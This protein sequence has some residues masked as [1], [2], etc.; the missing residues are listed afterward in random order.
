M[1]QLKLYSRLVYAIVYGYDVL[2][3]NCRHCCNSGTL[4]KPAGNY[5][6]SVDRLLYIYI[7]VSTGGLPLCRIQSVV[8]RGID[9]KLS[10]CRVTARRAVSCGWNRVK[11]R[12]CTNVRQIA[13]EKP[14][15]RRM[16]FKVI[17]GHWKWQKSLGHM[18]EAV[19]HWSGNFPLFPSLPLSFPPLLLL[20][21]SLF[22]SLPSAPPF[23]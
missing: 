15:N 20:F 1:Q 17:K 6:G 3:A 18:Q 8:I 9:K 7:V 21:F 5:A 19:W 4:I 11:C 2:R 14:C 12:F 23:L 13:F 22:P 16:T 10:C